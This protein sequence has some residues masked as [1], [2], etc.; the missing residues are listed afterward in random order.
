MANRVVRGKP[1]HKWAP[2]R[3]L[4]RPLSSEAELLL[5]QAQFFQ[6]WMWASI[7]I[8]VREGLSPA[9]AEAL[10]RDAEQAFEKFRSLPSLIARALEGRVHG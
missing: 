10:N 1:M 6:G 4:V 9:M 8:L 2:R 3:V 7:D 5:S